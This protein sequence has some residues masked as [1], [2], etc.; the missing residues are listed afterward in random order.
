MNTT[1]YIDIFVS[2][3]WK[4]NKDYYQLIENLEI[5]TANLVYTIDLFPNS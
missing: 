5:G 4:Y 1:K 2:H 3:R